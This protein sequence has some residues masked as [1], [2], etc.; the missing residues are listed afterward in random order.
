MGST[1]TTSTVHTCDRCGKTH[2][3]GSTPPGIAS[4]NWATLRWS[5]SAGFDYSGVPWGERVPNPIL[6]CGVCADD[7]AAAANSTKPIAQLLAIAA[8]VE[9]LQEPDGG[10]NCIPPGPEREAL[11]NAMN[12]WRVKPS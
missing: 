1:T 12:N 6:L 4:N 7:V 9:A 10:L 2:V 8:A 5:Q 11:E 3:G